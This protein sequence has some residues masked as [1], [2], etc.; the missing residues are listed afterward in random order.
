[1]ST[2][3]TLLRWRSLCLLPILCFAIDLPASAGTLDERELK[4]ATT[5]IVSEAGDHRLVLLGEMH[6]TR[7]IP[8]LVGRLLSLYSD[9]GPVRLG[10]EVDS[11]ENAALSAYCA[12]DGGPRAQAA[13]RDTPFWNVEGVQ[14]DGRRNYEML[15]LIEQVRRLRVGGRDV[16]IVPFDETGTGHTSSQARDEAMAIRLRA[17]LASLPRGRLLVLSGNVHAMRERPSDAPVQMQ[18]PMGSYLRDLNPYSI[19]IIANSG[20]FWACMKTCGPVTVPALRQTSGRMSDGP[21]D[22]EVVLPR[23]TI[24]HLI[25]AK[26]THSIR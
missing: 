20:A 22:L 26:D 9:Q 17:A 8:E 15:A 16:A 11:S 24:A 7:E 5:L 2:G 25:G 21:Y 10:I 18:T 3:P 13:L 6:G 12:S 19:D 1:M 23:F 4:S 14:H